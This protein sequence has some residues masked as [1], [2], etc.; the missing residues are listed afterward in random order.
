MECSIDQLSEAVKFMFEAD[1]HEEQ[2]WTHTFYFDIPSVGMPY[3]TKVCRN[4]PKVCLPGSEP[5]DWIISRPERVLSSTQ[6]LD[7]ILANVSLCNKFYASDSHFDDGHLFSHYS[8]NK[9]GE[10]A[11]WFSALAPYEIDKIL[12]ERSVGFC[13]VSKKIRGGL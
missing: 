8:A 10:R 11:V 3:I 7:L 12:I 1:F 13:G 9:D 2:P 4:L 6:A 5:E